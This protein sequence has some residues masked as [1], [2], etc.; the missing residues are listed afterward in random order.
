MIHKAV[1]PWDTPDEEQP[2]DINLDTPAD[3]ILMLLAGGLI[4]CCIWFSGG[5]SWTSLIGAILSAMYLLLKVLV[6]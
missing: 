4:V 5:F 6:R 2:I 3:R 1:F